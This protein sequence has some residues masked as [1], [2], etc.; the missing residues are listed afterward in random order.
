MKLHKFKYEA[1]NPDG[2]LVKG[3][4]ETINRYTCLKYLES[5]NLKVK[6]LEDVSNI[7][8]RLNQIV[9]DSALPKKQLI[10]FL[11][12]LGALL[13]ADI[14]IMSA[15]EL[16][17]LQQKNKHRRR[18]FFEINQNIN[19]GFTFSDSLA[20]YQ[21]EFPKML[22]QMIEIGEISGK[23]AET[24]LKMA[25]YYEKQLKLTSSIKTTIRMPLIYLG[26][27]LLIAV[28]MVL[29]VFPSITTLFASL[30]NAQLPGVTVF[31][32]NA[33]DFFAEYGL[34][35]LAGIVSLALILYLLNRYIPDA[36]KQFTAFFL[37]IPIFG[38]L[39]QISNQIVIANSLAQMMSS[40]INSLLAVS[41]IKE[42]LNNV[43][44]KD[45]LGKTVDY[46]KDGQAFSK[47]FQ[48]SDYID[49]VMAKMISTGELV[50]DIP[51][52]MVNLAEYYN[53]M[54]E[55]R[56][57]KIKN[58]LQPILLVIV[59]AIVG[60]LLLAIMLP[61]LSLGEQI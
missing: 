6:A 5:K 56:I 12:Q 23:L 28:G 31:F 20:L 34:I 45:V 2:K 14:D 29:F 16:L 9:L 46:I 59:Y 48:E 17:A 10:L 54:S 41:T 61:M 22:V 57:E 4:F 21:K 1:I 40:G 19:N 13:K 43:I 15:L 26:V 47:S 35:V 18:L 33:S 11:K 60:L 50:G 52:F 24:I 44:Y 25:D 8:T 51:N 39:I 49:R 55:I 42:L 58:A 7:F 30:G 32:L 3:T 38:Q 53:D 37:K 36:H 27:T